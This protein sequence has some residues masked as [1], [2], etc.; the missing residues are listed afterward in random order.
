VASPDLPPVLVARIERVGGEHAAGVNADA[1]GATARSCARR[2]RS[3][4][5]VGRGQGA[6]RVA[7]DRGARFPRSRQPRLISPSTTRCWCRR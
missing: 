7:H 3:K 4:S 5:A 2:S 6:H 1:V